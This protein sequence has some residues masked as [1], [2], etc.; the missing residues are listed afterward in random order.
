[1]WE[2]V[3][4]ALGIEPPGFAELTALFPHCPVH[5]PELQVESLP[6]VYGTFVPEPKSELER[7]ARLFPFANTC[8]YGACWG[9]EATH[10]DVLYCV[11]C[12]AALRGSNSES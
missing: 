9:G 10:R 7:A 12:R 2:P 4:I 5:G 3:R 8:A 1:M 11:A 6:I